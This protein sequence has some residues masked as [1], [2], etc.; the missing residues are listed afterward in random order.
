MY[1]SISDSW[2]AHMFWGSTSRSNL[3]NLLPLPSLFLPSPC[4]S[5]HLPLP[6]APGFAHMFPPVTELLRRAAATW[7]KSRQRQD[8]VNWPS[9]PHMGPS[10]AHTT[11]DEHL[12]I[13]HLAHTWAHLLPTQYLVHI[14]AELLPTQHLAHVCCIGLHN[15]AY[16]ILPTQYCLHNIAYTISIAYT[17]FGP[18][19][20]G[21]IYCQYSNWPTYE[22]IYCICSNWPTYEPIY[23]PYSNWPTYGPIYCPYSNWPTYE[24]IYCPY[25]NWPTYDPIYCPT[26]YI[27][28]CTLISDLRG[29]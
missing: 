3:S 25:S 24:P 19:T 14:W 4:L 28:L 21:P 29:Y 6:R 11:F 15:I 18:C 5:S 9:D 23:C 22:P 16:A 1:P 8:R 7:E 26:Y 12:P 10:V 13:K 20:Y 27:N 2:F 17:I